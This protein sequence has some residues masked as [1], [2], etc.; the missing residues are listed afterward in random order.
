[1]FDRRKKKIVR[2]KRFCKNQSVGSQDRILKNRGNQRIRNFKKLKNDFEI[3]GI[4]WHLLD[5]FVPLL[6]CESVY[7]NTVCISTRL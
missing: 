4:N 1:M 5:Y 2:R 7:G 3:T 6:H